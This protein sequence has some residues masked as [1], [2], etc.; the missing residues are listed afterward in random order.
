MLRPMLSL[1]LTYEFSWRPPGS[2]CTFIEVT[3][4]NSH[5]IFAIDDSTITIILVNIYIFY[6]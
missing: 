5:N 2:G 3:Q 4:V 6:L 1:K